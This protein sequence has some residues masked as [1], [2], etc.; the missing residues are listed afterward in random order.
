MIYEYIIIIIFL[1]I[2]A[3]ITIE[4]IDILRLFIP[5]LFRPSKQTMDKLCAD[6]LKEADEVIKARKNKDAQ[7]LFY[8]KIGD[9]SSSMDEIVDNL[10]KVLKKNNVKVK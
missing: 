8:E 9:T 7:L 10:I 3:D 2:A 1:I 5:C 6:M 4:G